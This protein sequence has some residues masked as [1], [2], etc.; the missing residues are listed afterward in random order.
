MKHSRNPRWLGLLFGILILCQTLTGLASCAAAEEIAFETEIT[1]VELNQ[2]GER[3]SVSA[4]LSADDTALYKNSTVCLFALEPFQNVAL[5]GNGTLKPIAE[6]RGTES[7]HFTVD[8]FFADGTRNRLT[9]R[10]LLAARDE[11]GVYS[12][13]TDGVYLSNPEVLAEG[14]FSGSSDSLKGLAISARDDVTLLSPSHTVIDLPLEEY[15]LSSPKYGNT[16]AYLYG[17]ETL[18]LSENA[19]EALDEQVKRLGAMGSQIYLRPLLLTLPEKENELSAI[20][21][22]DSA[23]ASAYALNLGNEDSYFYIA[24][25]FSFLAE[26]YPHVAGVIPGMAL[27]DSRYNS[28]TV[29]SFE[30]YME[31]TL[32]LMRVAYN[33]FRAK[34]AGVEVYL[35]VTNLFTTDGALGATERA[36]R[37]FLGAFAAYAERSGDFDWSV[38]LLMRSSVAGN[39]LYTE[40]GTVNEE[41]VTE[42]YVLPQTQ[43]LLS[44]LLATEELLYVTLQREVIWGLSVAG[45]GEAGA[46]NQR[47]SLLY[48][49]MKAI[50][51][52][53]EA[54][55]TPIRAVVW[56]TLTDSDVST[57]GLL[58]SGGAQ[59]PAGTLFSLLGRSDFAKVVDLSG[60]ESKL[61]TRYAEISSAITDRAESTVVYSGT[62]VGADG[63]S[64]NSQGTLLFGE[65]IGWGNAFSAL[66]GSGSVAVRRQHYDT[67]PMLVATFE[68][69]VGSGIYTASIPASQIRKRNLLALTVTAALPAGHAGA[70]VQV[71]LF[72]QSRGKFLRY[73]GEGT[74]IDGQWTTMTF[75][76]EEFASEIDGGQL[77]LTVSLLNTGATEDAPVTF[78]LSKVEVFETRSWFLRG[79]WILFL[80]LVILAA[81]TV[82]AIWFFQTY[83]IRWTMGGDRANRGANRPKNK[84]RGK[85][86]LKAFFGRIGELFREHTDIQRRISRKRIMEKPGSVKNDRNGGYGLDDLYTGDADDDDG[87]RD[88]DGDDTDTFSEDVKVEKPPKN[89]ETPSGEDGRN[90]QNGGNGKNGKDGDGDDDDH[91][92][93][94]GNGDNGDDDLLLPEFPEPEDLRPNEIG[95]FPPDGNGDAR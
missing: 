22:A 66:P 76:V 85:F 32:S 61:G 4:T 19:V 21:F 64:E 47:L 92:N 93:S 74:V 88:G 94:D 54:K 11:N 81:L 56:E 57:E 78:Y 52:N 3:V 58:T 71:S 90:D 75:D 73:V 65:G 84:T 16:I 25:F 82:L 67:A 5:I 95:D 45:G 86:S 2:S 53:A 49:Y 35:P 24:G 28:S 72:G 83:E 77:T 68:S 23:E 1:S 60:T 40:S 39:T 20:G 62:A 14:G 44:D 31:N 34:N 26:R 15:I 87:D 37:E 36:A 43:S 79:G 6:V 91:G 18:S 38:Y 51:H 50:A 46:E 29:A 30:I 9:Q 69:G 12:V 8:F 42:K 48:A 10:F 63:S 41:G 27:N 59:K 70:E 7:M 80:V 55:N 33:I 17:G 13:I 89:G